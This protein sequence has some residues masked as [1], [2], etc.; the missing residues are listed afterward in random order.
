M[1]SFSLDVRY[2]DTC[3]YFIDI[4][5]ATNA[6]YVEQNIMNMARHEIFW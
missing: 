6:Q 4:H 5:I 2:L 1:G 3:T